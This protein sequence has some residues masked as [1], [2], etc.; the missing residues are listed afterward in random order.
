ME[1]EWVYHLDDERGRN[2]S[3]AKALWVCSLEKQ[4]VMPKGFH[5]KGI[6]DGIRWG[7]VGDGTTAEGDM[8][9]A[10]NAASVWDLPLHF[11]CHRQRRCHQQNQMKVESK[12][13]QRMPKGLGCVIFSCHGGDFWDV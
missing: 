4:L 6:R 12:I 9:D 7:S 8:H 3:C 2:P 13:L 1:D 11:T 5:L 10:M